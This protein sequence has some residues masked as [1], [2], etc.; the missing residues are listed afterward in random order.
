TTLR[1]PAGASP[2]FSSLKSNTFSAD[3]TYGPHSSS[4]PAPI[5]NRRIGPT[6][7]NHPALR[8]CPDLIVDTLSR[9]ETTLHRNGSCL[10][11]SCSVSLPVTQQVTKTHFSP[12]R[13]ARRWQAP[14]S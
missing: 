4:T 5:V 12:S 14:C 3:R 11:Q 13:P 9:I 8:H 2:V 10:T 7:T 1:N 6:L